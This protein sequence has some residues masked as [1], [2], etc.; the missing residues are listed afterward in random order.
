MIRY[1]IND[2]GDT[3]DLEAL[4]AAVI[5]PVLD[6]IVQ[7]ADALTPIYR[8]LLDWLARPE[9]VAAVYRIEHLPPMCHPSGRIGREVRRRRKLLTVDRRIERN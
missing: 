7:M 3:V 9:V 1:I 6:T 5:A 8:N 4:A 2:R